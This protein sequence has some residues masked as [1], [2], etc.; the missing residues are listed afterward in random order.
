MFSFT[1]VAASFDSDIC[2]LVLS[3]PL[4]FNEFVGAVPMPKQGEEF[5][6]DAVVSGWGT[7]SSGGSTPDELRYVTVPLV[8]DASMLTN[9]QK[10]P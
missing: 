2:I 5:T 4:E 7:L 8:D 10:S 6:G 9:H 3:E 1:D